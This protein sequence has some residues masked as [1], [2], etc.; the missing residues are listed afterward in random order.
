MHVHVLS[1]DGEAKFLIKPVIALADYSAFSEIQLREIERIVKKYAK[2][3]E[4]AWN[5]HFNS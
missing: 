2:E 1:P 5:E 3:I 4:K